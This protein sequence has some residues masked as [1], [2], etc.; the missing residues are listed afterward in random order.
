[1]QPPAQGQVGEE[2]DGQTPRALPHVAEGEEAS[3][4]GAPLMAEKDEAD[5]VQSAPSHDM[6]VVGGGG[7]GGRE[8]A[9]LMAAKRPGKPQRREKQ[10]N[11]KRGTWEAKLA[12]PQ[13][14]EKRTIQFCQKNSS[15]IGTSP[16]ESRERE[17]A[18][19]CHTSS[20]LE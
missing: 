17:Q 15:W 1:M 7:G 16:W 10:K 19:P 2:K 20:R 13:A 4:P 18:Q 6:G 9:A 11:G 12:G 5:Q 3:V 8:A 14:S